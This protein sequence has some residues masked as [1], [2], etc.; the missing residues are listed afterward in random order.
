MA[1]LQRDHDVGIHGANG[2]RV[3]VS[4]V[5]GAVRQTDVVDDAGQFVGGN[6]FRM[7]VS[8][9]SASRAVSSMRVPVLAR[10]CR[11][12]WPASVTGKKSWPSQ[13]ISRNAA[14]QRPRNNGT[15]NS[16][17]RM[18]CRA[19]SDT[20]RAG[21]KAALE[22]ALQTRERCSRTP[23][24]VAWCVPGLIRYMRQRRDQRARKDVG[25]QHGEHHG[26]GQRNER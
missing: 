20:Q 10:K 9:R 12:N 13:G 23:A 25:R 2:G 7:E 3:A 19:S 18:Q 5:D 4:G 11:L 6:R 22:R 21:F 8:I 24:R 26:F 16:R 14:A 17:W 15:K 1:G